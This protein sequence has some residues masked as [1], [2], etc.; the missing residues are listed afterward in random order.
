MWAIAKKFK[1]RLCKDPTQP[2]R[3]STAQR[4]GGSVS[5]KLGLTTKMSAEGARSTRLV[6]SGPSTSR[7]GRAG[8]LTERSENATARLEEDARAAEALVLLGIGP[9]SSVA[10]IRRAYKKAALDTHP[11]KVGDDSQFL[12]VQDAYDFLIALSEKRAEERR[13]ERQ[14]KCEEEYARWEKERAKQLVAAVAAPDAIDESFRAWE[15]PTYRQPSRAAVMSPCASDKDN[16]FN[17]KTF[18]KKGWSSPQPT[19]SF[20]ASLS[21]RQPITALEC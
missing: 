14:A 15:R 13:R 10:D 17:S 5:A 16:P 19:A 7:T 21:V 12:A 20:R 6:K 8:P 18:F 1:N 2:N 3:S 9:S 11:D 4:V